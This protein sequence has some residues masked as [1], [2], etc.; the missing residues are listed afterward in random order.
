MQVPRQQM[1]EQDAQDRVRNFTEV[2]LG[3]TP[4]MAMLEARRCLECRK[5]TCMSGCPVGVDIPAFLTLIVEGKFV[6]AAWKIKE[7]NILPAIC[8]RVCPQDEQCEKLCLVGKKKH[9]IGIGMLER[10]VADYE[11]STGEVRIP[12]VGEPTGCK[13]AVVGSGPAGLTAAFELAKRGHTVTIFEA[14]HRP[15]GVLFYGIPRFRLPAEVIEAEIDVLKQMGVEIILNAPVGKV[16]TID[17]LLNEEGCDAIFV[18]TGAG[19]P[20]FTNLPGENL[21]GI[22]SANE[23]LTRINLMRAD[24]FPNNATPVYCGQRVAVIGAGNTAMDAARVSLRMSPEEV[25]IFYRRTRNEAP[26]R[27]EELEHAIQEGVQFHWLTAP[28]RFIGDDNYFVKQIEVQKME[29]GEPD[30]SG[31]RRPV[32]I[33]GSEE[34]YD[35]DTVV[36]ALGFGVN[37]LITDSTPEIETNKWGVVQVNKETGE[38][39]KE[40]VFAAGDVITGGAT[41]ILA[42]GQART[43]ALGLHNWLIERKGLDMP[44]EATALEAV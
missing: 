19:L 41:V 21:N 15:G 6:E 27:T 3:L 44:V 43:A 37:P 32:P 22:Y 29:L 10:F 33:P 30:A 1:P 18:G 2:P 35:V 8:G 25:H 40:G 9:P 23:Y 28:T 5:P 11:R 38:T 14:L 7:T 31:R 42:M 34:V 39:S 16:V 4:D 17:E 13:V 24:Q 26:A 20:W 36:L 12:N